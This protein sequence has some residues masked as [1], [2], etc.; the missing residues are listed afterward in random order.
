M[1]RHKLSGKSRHLYRTIGTL[2]FRIFFSDWPGVLLLF[3]FSC[4]QRNKKK[5]H[6]CR[7]FTEIVYWLTSFCLTLSLN[8]ICLLNIFSWKFLVKSF[9]R[10]KRC[11]Q[12]NL[13]SFTASFYCPFNISQLNEVGVYNNQQNVGEMI[14]C[15]SNVVHF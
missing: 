11:G 1:L 4:H 5:I 13:C 10:V 12:V 2:N 7:S 3:F 14:W 6:Q 9:K 15:I 8:I